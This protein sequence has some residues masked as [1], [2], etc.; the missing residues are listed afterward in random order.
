[1]LNKKNV[2]L[3]L[4]ILLVIP[5]SNALGVASAQDISFFDADPSIVGLLVILAF[6]SILAT[7]A[8]FALNQNGSGNV[9]QN[10]G[11]KIDVST[12]LVIGIVA[13]F[14]LFI[15]AISAKIYTIA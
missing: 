7:F 2:L 3:I 10:I 6:L 9:Y 14:V 8:Y 4:F 12:I 5:L 1:M 13:L 11:S 15:I